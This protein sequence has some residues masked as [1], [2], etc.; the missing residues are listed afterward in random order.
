MR[1]A[2]TNHAAK[3]ATK[4]TATGEV[5]CAQLYSMFDAITAQKT[6]SCSSFQSMAEG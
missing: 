2:V 4:A 1:S 5:P 6:A 3:A